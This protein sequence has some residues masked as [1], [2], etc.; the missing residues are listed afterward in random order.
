MSFIFTDVI[1]P[2]LNSSVDSPIATASCASTQRNTGSGDFEFK[3]VIE[4]VSCLIVNFLQVSIVQWKTFM[5]PH[6]VS[7]FQGV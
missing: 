6:I 4:D 2:V 7:N 5:Q 1:L 3:D